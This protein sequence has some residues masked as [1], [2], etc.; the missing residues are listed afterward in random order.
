MANDNEKRRKRDIMD[1]DFIEDNG[2]LDFDDDDDIDSYYA[3]PDRSNEIRRRRKQFTVIGILIVILCIICVAAMMT[4]TLIKKYTPNKNQISLYEYYN[5]DVA[6]ESVDMPVA[7]IY[8]NGVLINGNAY[9][10][11]DNWY[12]TMDFVKEMFNDRFYYDKGNDEIIFT[13]P[14]KIITLPMDSQVYYN[15]DEIKKESYT[16]VKKVDD[17]I[18]IAIDY[19]K[20]KADFL[21][22]IRTAPYRM[23]LTREYGTHTYA[24]VAAE[25]NIRLKDSI[26]G[27]I[28]SVGR[29][30]YNWKVVSE[31]DDW[32]LLETDDG[33]RGY[34]R[35]KEID[36]SYKV[37]VT[38]N[39]QTPVYT[40]IS[41]D[42]KINL[43]WHAIYGENDNQKVYAF[44]D[45]TEGVN[46]VSPTWYQILDA[47]GNWNSYAE[48]WYVEYIHSLGMEIWPLISD[49]ISVDPENGWDEEVL[50]GTTENRRNLI[51]NLMNEVNTYGYDGINLDFEKIAKENGENYIQFVRELS[52]ECRKAGV[53]LAI[54]N[55]VP[56]PH[57][58]HYDR[59]EQ[60]VVADYVIVMGYD[61]HYDGSE[62][63][64]VA[65]IGFV[66]RGIENTC[67]VVPASKV[68]N[69]LPFYTRM[70]MEGTDSEGNAVNKTK[71]YTMKAALDFVTENGFETH[72]D[73]EV[74]QY[75]ATGSIENINYQVWLEDDKSLEAKMKVVQQYKIGGVAC[76]DLGSESESVWN[77][78]NN[79]NHN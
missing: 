51:N 15:D 1:S 56:M 69:A 64:S 22:E 77:I 13:T 75:V 24:D 50:L 10:I 67:A 46:T 18:Y 44:L 16:I 54:D 26:K 45:A 7:P 25:A 66:T 57:T 21:Y 55:Y 42:Y 20:E 43:V 2:D 53:V 48:Q 8:E 41:K 49:F 36:G 74:C 61:E 79:Y 59:E 33:Q 11:G 12:F 5:A 58:A 70:W 29:G 3:E 68:I 62:A 32:T 60:G 34:V 39:F 23:V 30:G 47:E 78:I 6:A 71:A 27:D 72:W 37:D 73:E 28:L 14:S 52:I 63:G 4:V 31:A 40:S 35:T 17:V 65:S 76:W 38:N 19:V 9:L